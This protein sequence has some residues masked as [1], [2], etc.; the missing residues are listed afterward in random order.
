MAKLRS[1]GK[2]EKKL[3]C[4]KCK[5]SDHLPKDCP[6]VNKRTQAK[7]SSAKKNQEIIKPVDVT[8][9]ITE[10][11]SDKEVSTETLTAKKNPK[12]KKAEENTEKTVP[13]RKRTQRETNESSTKDSIAKENQEGN[14]ASLSE[15]ENTKKA[16]ATKKATPKKPRK[17]TKT[18]RN[19]EE[20]LTTKENQETNDASLQEENTKKPTPIKKATPKK[21]RKSTK[22]EI[23]TIVET[24]PTKELIAKENQK[25][26]ESSL[27]EE[28]NTQTAAATKKETPKIARKSTISERNTD[29]TVAESIAKKNQEFDDTSLLHVGENTK[30]AAPTRRSIAKKSDA[31]KETIEK[32]ISTKKSIIKKNSEHG[33]YEKNQG[34]AVSTK[35]SIPEKAPVV[36][37]NTEKVASN[38][39]SITEKNHEIAENLKQAVPTEESSGNDESNELE[40]IVTERS[41]EEIPTQLLSSKKKREID[42]S[43]DIETGITEEKNKEA[44]SVKSSNEETNYEG[45]KAFDLNSY[46]TDENKEKLISIEPL[47]QKKEDGLNDIPEF[48]SSKSLVKKKKSVIEKENSI[49]KSDKSSDRLKL[50][51]YTTGKPH[52]EIGKSDYLESKY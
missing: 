7:R 8:N 41:T 21:T 1:R 16:A 25:I 17:S 51:Q 15:Q 27:Q 39:A 34:K 38:T 33:M 13:S 5:N 10:E 20:T 35:T 52:H 47:I 29:K 24:I 3:F 42:K 45:K 31:V 46:I 18:E 49:Q 9:N 36:E 4:Y 40:T 19:I 14:D 28:E 43:F 50:K 37:E 23:N 6:T 44:V 26:D 11:N 48:S 12:R 32:V 22:A 2:V 30:K